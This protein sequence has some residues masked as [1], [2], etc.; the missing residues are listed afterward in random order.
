MG[1]K[2]SRLK[3]KKKNTLRK[4]EMMMFIWSYYRDYA[5]DWMFVFQK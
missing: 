5:A 2:N 3:K 1:I 4:P